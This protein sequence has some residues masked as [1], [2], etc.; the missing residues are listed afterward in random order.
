[1]TTLHPA[2]LVVIQSLLQECAPPH[3]SEQLTCEPETLLPEEILNGVTE[4]GDSVLAIVQQQV[5]E[6]LAA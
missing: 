2:T 5:T 1:M 3:L 6:L 4:E